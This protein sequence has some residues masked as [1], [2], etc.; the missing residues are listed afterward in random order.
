[1]VF[2]TT[3]VMIGESSPATPVTI[4]DE[5]SRDSMFAVSLRRC[6]LQIFRAVVSLD[7]VEM[8]DSMPFGGRANKGSGDEGVYGIES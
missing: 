2:V 6:P 8:I 1:M 5:A 3:G 4:R 7:A